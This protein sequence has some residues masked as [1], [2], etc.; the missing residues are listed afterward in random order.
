VRGNE[1]RGLGISGE[2]RLLAL[3]G[4]PVRHSLSPRMHNT[5]FAE[6][7]LSYA[8]LAF[9]VGPAE[10]AGAVAALKAL[11]ARGFNLTM[12]LK[13]LIVPLLDD[14][15][16][17]ARL[18]ASVNT[19]AIE[20]GRLIGHNTDGKGHIRDL[21]DHGVAV[22][23]RRFILAGAGG[24]AQGLAVQ[25]ALDGAAELVI[26][27][28]SLERAEAL[29]DLLHQHLPACRVEAIALSS[30][31]PAGFEA[32]LAEADI[33]VNCTSLGMHPHEEG[34]IIASPAALRP[35]L[36]VADL[37]YLPRKTVLLEFAEEAGCQAIDG[38]GTLLWQGAEAF[39]IWT[40]QDMPV[41]LVRKRVFPDTQS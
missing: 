1:I 20:D 3:L 7:G 16:P 2:T 19:V 4:D 24:A 27:N 11:D 18:T 26:A 37:V 10:L 32:R 28:R 31:G 34:C 41:E 39:R 14:L 13:K 25:L 15:S 9:R 33:L 17:A 29:R 21:R 6:L 12:P 40:G 38:T 23:G 22:R 36:V 30:T 5:A 8:Y 35:G